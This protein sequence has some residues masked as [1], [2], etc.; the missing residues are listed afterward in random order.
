MVAAVVAVAVADGQAAVKGEALGGWTVVDTRETTDPYTRG[1]MWGKAGREAYFAA[2]TTFEAVTLETTGK[3]LGFFEAAAVELYMDKIPAE[4][5]AEIKGIADGIGVTPEEIVG[6]NS[7]IEMTGSWWPTQ[8]PHLNM[9]MRN[10][11]CSAFVATGSATADGGVVIGHTTFLEFWSGQYFTWVYKLATTAAAGEIVMQTM[12]GYV[13]SMSDWWLTGA[14]LAVVE[15]TIANFYGY[16]PSGMPEWV[17]AR[18]AAESAVDIASF[19]AALDNGNN[20]G[21]ASMW[22][23]ADIKTGEIARFEQGLKY[24]SLATL[25]D[26]VFTGANVAE[27]PRIRNLECFDSGYSDVRANTGARR[28]VWS[29]LVDEHYGNIT[30]AQ[31]LSD[32]TAVWAV[33]FFPAGSTDAKVANAT[34]IA[35]LAFHA[36]TG[37]ANGF[38]FD[39]A[40]YYADHP[41]WAWLAPHLLDRPSQPMVYIA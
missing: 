19:V 38:A 37:R 6:W 15:T 16:D 17:R 3:T 36:R 34:D 28:V 8:A 4:L 20:G 22:L 1:L 40:A 11:H 24:T 33:P 5:L 13:A 25:T 29:M 9:H 7:Y 2:R 14:G 10:S 21:Y 35:A 23:V 30:T 32:P 39:A 41:Q 12:P 27:D 26:G 18:L 31:Y